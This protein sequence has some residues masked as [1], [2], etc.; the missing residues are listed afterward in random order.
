M[1]RITEARMAGRSTGSVT[2]VSVRRA[3]A[4]HTLEDSS[5]ETSKALMAGAMIR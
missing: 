2:R 3:E 5:S 4:P 1:T